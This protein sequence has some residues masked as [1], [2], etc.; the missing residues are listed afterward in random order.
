MR[1]RSGIF[2]APERRI[3]SAEMTKTAAAVSEVFCAFFETE[4]T[5]MFIRSTRLIC[6]ISAAQLVLDS[7]RAAPP[8]KPADSSA[9]HPE[10]RSIEDA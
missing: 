5:S 2:S 3:S 4:V 1:S 7:A 6:R 8:I 10:E 9:G